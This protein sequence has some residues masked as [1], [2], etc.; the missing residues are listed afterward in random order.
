MCLLTKLLRRF[1][2]EKSNLYVIF[3]EKNEL[4]V[5]EVANFLFSGVKV[6]GASETCM[7]FLY[8]NQDRFAFRVSFINCICG[9][10]SGF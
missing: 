8:E 10:L 1:F 4:P 7:K 6:V 9:L 3:R 5:C 2:L